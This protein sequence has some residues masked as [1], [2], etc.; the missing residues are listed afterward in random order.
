MACDV[1]SNA[2]IFR[3]EAFKTVDLHATF[4]IDPTRFISI[5]V[6]METQAF[7]I[8]S[9]GS[10]LVLNCMLFMYTARAMLSH[11]FSIGFKSGDFADHAD[12]VV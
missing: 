4:F 3:L 2:L 11:I 10:V 7:L 9:P 6:G 1:A 12:L 8:V 5:N